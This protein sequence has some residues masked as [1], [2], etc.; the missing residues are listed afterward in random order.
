[1]ES[2]YQQ[3]IDDPE[4]V[5]PQW[6]PFFEGFQLGYE[7]M[8]DPAAD[9]DAPTAS[10][11]GHTTGGDLQSRVDRLIDRHRNLG[12]LAAHLNPLEAAP[13]IPQDLELAALGLDTVDPDT[14]VNPGTLPMEGPATLGAVTEQLRRSWCGRLGAEISHIR[15]L[16][17]QQWLIE[18]I[19]RIPTEPDLEEDIR[20]RILRELVQAT[21]L[22]QFLMRRYIGKKWFSLEGNETLIPMLNEL[23][24][25]ASAGGVEELA[26]GM[27]HR[28]RINV[29]V[30]ILEKSY[31]QLFTEFEESWAED[32][33]QGGG[34]V[35]YHRGFSSDVITDAGRPVHLAMASNPSHLE[36][37]HPVS[38]GRVRAKQRLRN[39][40]ERDRC[41]PI[42]M[43]G[44]ASLPGQGIV[45]ETF[46]L[47]ELPGYTV[48]GT[49]HIVINNQIGF[50]TEP[51]DLFTGTY[52]T[53]IA[54]AYDIPVLHV[55]GFD[56]DLCVRVMMLAYEYRQRFQKDVVIDLYGYRKYGHNETDEPAFTQPVMY[57][58]IRNM[59]PVV[60][61]Y[62]DTLL[63]EGVISREEYEAAK[64]RVQNLMDESQERIR[65]KPVEPTP[66]AFDDHSAWGGFSPTYD[67]T[68]ADTT[69]DRAQ[70]EV[71]AKALGSIPEGFKPHRKLERVLEQRANA[72]GQDEPLD[73][74]MGELLA[75]GT[76]LSEGTSVR[77]TGEDVMR[78]TFSH[79]HAGLFHADHGEEYV[80]LNHIDD[81]QAHICIHNSPVTEGGCIGFEYGYSLGD[82]NM[83]VVWE[84]QFG[85]FA[86]AGQVFFDQFI[87][88]AARKWARHSG[89]TMLLPHGYEGQGPE[90]SSARIERFLQLSAND[91]MEIVN[92]TTPAQ[93]FHLLRR[94][95]KRN[96]RTPLIIFSPK[97]LLRHPAA[98]SPVADF[99]RTGFQ[100]VIDDP[101]IKNP[102]T[103]ERVLFCTGK[104]FYDLA[105]HCEKVEA[106]HAAIVRIE[107]MHPFPIDEVRK[108]L[109][110]YKGTKK[111]IWVQEEPRNMGAWTFINEQF[112]ERLG[113]QL[114]YVGRPDNDTPAVASTK[115]HAT[116]QHRLVTDAI[117]IEPASIASS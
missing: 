5:D 15:D 1:V 63:A 90:H 79:R 49:I 64:H 104:V 114:N 70:L 115:M 13:A 68:A 50:T 83:L 4:S 10:L 34:D 106:G 92:P 39:D 105:S 46:N 48:G 53:D 66:P 8:P 117:G 89:M 2:L 26:F 97:S 25:I 81:A 71:V 88:S 24:T 19:E 35:K 22:E 32:F 62:A 14:P 20:K 17:Q 113:V 82:P 56:P 33:I 84:A 65:E 73:W 78:G 96:F 58:A 27:A 100:L 16:T 31:E 110:R 11:P 51:V 6:I 76:L 107:Q 77:L 36:W 67:W 45:Q 3:W 108:I 44:D 116:E 111:F 103:V 38:L 30:N 52:C 28:G 98:R 74:A 47:S 21:G 37:G 101:K 42:L 12:H 94:Q 40:E 75:Y 95:M 23:L 54:R 99:E 57:Q 18:H 72:I 43:H 86:N 93:I 29:L 55:N 102:D 61:Q 109:D 87:A 59:I 7:R 41:I 80:G 112:S 9:A 85:D 60:E 69:V 91:N